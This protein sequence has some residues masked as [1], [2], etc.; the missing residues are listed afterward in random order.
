MAK[1][2]IAAAAKEGRILVSDGAWGTFLFRKGLK[3]G[4]CPELWCADHPDDV[5]DIAA[6]YLA[7]GADMVE[8]NSFGGTSTALARHGFAARAAELNESAARLSREA[9]S[10]RGAKGSQAWVIG[11]M[12]PTGKML[13]MG[14]VT[15]EEAFAAFGEQAEALARGGVDALC[16]ETMSEGEEAVIAVRAAKEAAGLEVICTFTFDRTAQGYYRTMMGLSPE[17]AAAAALDAGA[18]IIGTNCGNG[19]AGMIDV[20][21]A[22]RPYARGLPIMVQANAGLPTNIDGVDAYPEGPEDMAALVPKLLDAG[23]NIVGGCCGTTPAHIAAIRKA[24]DEYM[25]ARVP[26]ATG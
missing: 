13:V 25:A 8:T 12:G 4:E 1:T 7:S 5:R 18:D 21:R 24:V 11:S 6:S 3:Q 20:V 22:M 2:S 19:F 14:D 9:L 15:P 26:G 10:R 16:I 17:N 23:A